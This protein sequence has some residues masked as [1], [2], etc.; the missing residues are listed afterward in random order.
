MPNLYGM[1]ILE[2]VDSLV[3]M[4]RHL[5]ED[6]ADDESRYGDTL[7]QFNRTRQHLVDRLAELYH[8]GSLGGRTQHL[9]GRDALQGRSLWEGRRR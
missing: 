6:A 5:P 2:L 3:T 1:T 9:I 7:E 8:G 4:A